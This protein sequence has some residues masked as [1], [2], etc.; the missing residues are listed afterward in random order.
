MNLSF[1]AACAA[2]CYLSAM[3]AAVKH[4]DKVPPWLVVFIDISLCRMHTLRWWKH[5][6]AGPATDVEVSSSSPSVELNSLN[7]GAISSSGVEKAPGPDCHVDLDPV[8][9]EK[10]TWSRGSR[11]LD[12]MA[13]LVIPLLY[14]IIIGVMFSDI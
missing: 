2:E 10:Y 5:E 14:A 12:R 3:M 4:D 6:S 13:R 7:N 8:D 1:V 11:A 9:E